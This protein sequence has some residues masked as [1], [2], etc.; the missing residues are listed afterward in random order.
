MAQFDVHRNASKRAGGPPYLLVVQ[1]SRFK[2]LPRRV[3][4]PLVRRELVGA[5]DERLSPQF[6][7][8][9]VSVVLAA[10]EMASLPLVAFGEHVGSLRA[11]G[12]DI[13]RAVDLVLSRAWD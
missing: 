10:L 9:G 3:A 12:D 8:A 13:V 1:S 6:D 7:V 11:R 4:I 5:I 2:D